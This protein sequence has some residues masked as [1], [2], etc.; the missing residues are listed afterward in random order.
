MDQ[1]SRLQLLFFK[2]VN[3]LFKSAMRILST[4]SIVQCGRF[5]TAGQPSSSIKFVQTETLLG[6]AQFMHMAETA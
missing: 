3:P 4:V 6:T 5:W 1:I 2:S